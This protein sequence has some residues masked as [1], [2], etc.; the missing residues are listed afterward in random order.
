[1]LLVVKK[2]E[3]AWPA[4]RTADGIGKL[5]LTWLDEKN[6][7]IISTFTDPHKIASM[8]YGY[9]DDEVHFYGAGFHSME[10]SLREGIL[11]LD[12]IQK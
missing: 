8:I 2:Y 3:G 11:V 9:D 4:N 6:A 1:V 5:I 12:K 10:C 7:K